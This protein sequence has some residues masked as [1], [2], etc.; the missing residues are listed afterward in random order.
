MLIKSPERYDPSMGSLSAFLSGVARNQVLKQLGKAKPYVELSEA[1]ASSHATGCEAALGDLT[2]Q[3]TINEVRSAVS[4]LPG[5]YRE[6]VMLCDL[7]EKSYS[8]AAETL[9]VPVGTVRSR[10]SRGRAMLLTRLKNAV[11][12]LA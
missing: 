5:G 7:E 3:E 11:R 10:L 2:R 6:A 8:E 9:G 1:V 4:S 12:S